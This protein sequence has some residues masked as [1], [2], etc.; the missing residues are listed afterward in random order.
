MGS[1]AGAPVEGSQTISEEK[2]G[3][4]IE[5][6]LPQLEEMSSGEDG[7]SGRFL[8]NVLIRWEFRQAKPAMRWRM[9]VSP[10]RQT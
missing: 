10:A 7:P 4:G 3:Q 8:A 9:R 6:G 1:Q 5:T 2:P